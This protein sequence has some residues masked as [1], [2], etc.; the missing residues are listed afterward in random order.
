MPTL[1]TAISTTVSSMN[2]QKEVMQFIKLNSKY[3]Y[4]INLT[5]SVTD[6]QKEMEG[7]HLF[8]GRGSN[9]RIM[10]ILP[11]ISNFNC[12][13]LEC[14]NLKALNSNYL[15][16]KN[17][18]FCGMETNMFYRFEHCQLC[19]QHPSI[20]LLSKQQIIDTIIDSQLK[21]YPYRNGIAESKIQMATQNIWWKQVLHNKTK[22][23]KGEKI[24]KLSDYEKNI[25]KEAKN[26]NL[27]F[28]YNPIPSH[29]FGFFTRW[30]T[31]TLLFPYECSNLLIFPLDKLHS[32]GK[33]NMELCFRFTSVIIFLFGKTNLLY[34]NNLSTIDH[35][36][37]T[38]DIYQPT[39][40]SPWGKKIERRLP[41]LSGNN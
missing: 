35:R 23:K 10:K 19:L 6:I 31:K 22:L 30:N 34:R 28:I 29:I 25:Q 2:Y 16:R 40:I 1:Q 4:L 20:G 21:A 41:G 3:K 39:G 26:N 8:V 36:I 33:G 18:R 14:T 17:C 27:K 7:I 32:F 11:I 12:D 24:L 9:Q 5:Q 38:F 13:N 37:A 15:C